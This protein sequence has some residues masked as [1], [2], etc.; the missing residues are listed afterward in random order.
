MVRLKLTIMSFLQFYVWGA[1][2]M[3][4]A[5]YWFGTMKWDGTKFGAVFST[6]GIASIFMPTLMG[7][8]ADKWINAERLY[9]ILHLLYAGALICL[10]QITNPETFFYIMLIAMVFYMPTIALT[11]SIS[12]T[13]LKK[14]NLDIIKNYPPIRVWGTIGF[15]AA[16]WTTNL[17]GFKAS[18][19]QFYLAAFVAVMLGIFAFTLPPCRPENS[20]AEKQS[21]FEVLGLNAFKLFANQKMA[22]FFLFSMFLGAALQL[23]NAFGDVFLDEFKHFPKYVDSFVVKYSTII[24]SISWT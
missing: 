13:V 18:E 4:L 22:M 24:M 8:V 14:N 1:W 19:N 2:L 3:T 20:K 16:M 5:I 15:I 23:T 17:S 6:M 21:I 12:Y 11:N 9:G 10:P 7:V